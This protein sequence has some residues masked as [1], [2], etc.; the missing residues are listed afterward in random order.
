MVLCT[1]PVSTEVLVWEICQKICLWFEY[2]NVKRLILLS[3]EWK[4]LCLC[5][6]TLNIII[7][8]IRQ[9]DCLLRQFLLP[10]SS[11]LSHF[12]TP[13]PMFPGLTA[14]IY[15]SQWSF[16]V[17]LVS[18]EIRTRQSVFNHR[19][20]GE[21]FHLS[22]LQFPHQ[23]SGDDDNNSSKRHYDEWLSS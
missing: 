6:M 14:Q 16:Y 18:G 21:L 7:N 9:C 1:R 11:S 22:M 23:S 10:A 5:S 12:F 20:L 19:V 17:E 13:L 8:W 4:H 2:F 15:F 3:R